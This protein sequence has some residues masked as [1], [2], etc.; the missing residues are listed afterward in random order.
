MEYIIAQKEDSKTVYKIVKETITSIYPKYYPK[1]I[2]DFFLQLHSIE[3][4]EKDIC[5]GNV[6]ILKEG[7]HCIGTGCYKDSHITRVYVLPE[8]QGEGYGTYIMN[9]LEQEIAKTHKHA[10]LDASLP[11]SHMYEKRGYYTIEHCKLEINDGSILVYEIMEKE[12]RKC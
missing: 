2:V 12:L 11:A 7:I 8:F 9:C 10:C 5:E 4:I 1:S 6:G 3:N